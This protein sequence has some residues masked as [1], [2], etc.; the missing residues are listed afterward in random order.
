MSSFFSYRTFSRIGSA[1]ATASITYSILPSVIMRWVSNLG[2][3]DERAE[4]GDG[5][6]HDQILHLVGAFIGIERFRIGKKARD[7]GID[8]N[9]IRAQKLARPGHGFAH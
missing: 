1:G 4:A 9:T 7:F 8:D 3:S 6:A 5:L 2:F